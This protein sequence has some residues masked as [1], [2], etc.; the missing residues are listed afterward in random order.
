[1]CSLQ[2]DM[3]EDLALGMLKSVSME[4]YVS[5]SQIS[6]RLWIALN[7]LHEDRKDHKVVSRD[8]RRVR[9]VADGKC[10]TSS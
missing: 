10:S 3:Q 6:A 9:L 8:C 4:S 5:V 1:M 7:V 2:Q